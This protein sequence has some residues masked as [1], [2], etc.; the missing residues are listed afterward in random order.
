MVKKVV[1]SV[2]WTLSVLFVGVVLVNLSPTILAGNTVLYVDPPALGGLK[3]G[4]IFKI[5][6]TVSNVVDLYA[7]QFSLYYRG[8]VL[9]A[10]LVEEGPFLKTHPDTDQTLFVTPIF[11]DSYN[12]THGLIISS[13]TLV[14]VKG[15][16]NGTG[17][18]VTITF[19]VKQAASSTLH[20]KGTKLV[21]SFEPFGRLISHSIVDGQAYSGIRDVAVL[22]V[23]VSSASVYVGESVM[24]DVVVANNGTGAETFDVTAYYDSSIIGR[25]TVGGLAPGSRANLTFYW[26]T[27]GVQPDRTYGIK[28]E[29]QAVPGEIMLGN[30]VFLDGSVL[31]R[32]HVP[33]AIKI[34]EAISCNQSGYQKTRFDAG[35]MAHFKV[36]V[37]STSEE[38]QMVLVTVNVGDSSNTTLG[39]VS[40]KGMIMPGASTF[41]LGL[42]IPSTVSTG[43]A[44]VYAN[45]FTD[46]PYFG[47]VPY[48]PEV[49]ATFEISGA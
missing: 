47:G 40:F 9:N 21:D 33:F 1:F 46:W 25:Q 35:S 29:A 22:N 20:L 27:T 31:V 10:T 2:I 5:N 16:V 48:C 41:I 14:A 32:S 4:D 18:L 8:D 37:N 23:Q 34:T 12:S 42:P 6:I 26:N 49:R 39:V 17:T 28:A 11:T 44:N 45:A 19:K 36:T 7:W 13:D 15:G 38:L 43:L 3:V 24:V 30:N